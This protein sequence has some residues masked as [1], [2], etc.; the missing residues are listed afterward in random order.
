MSKQLGQPKRDASQRVLD[1]RPK[2]WRIEPR[3]GFY[4][5]IDSTGG[6][7]ARPID[8][9]VAN[10]IVESVNELVLAVNERD[11]LAYEVLAADSLRASLLDAIRLHHNQHTDDLCWQDD[12]A[13]Y[14]AAGLPPRDHR[15]G[16]KTAMRANCDRFIENRCEGGGPW[17]SYAELEAENARLTTELANCKK[18]PYSR[19]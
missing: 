14:A 15:V 19:P 17:R 8:L 3:D 18:P 12:D 2:P 16:D 1:Q 10:E 11:S 7:I 9:A 6:F 5:I 13:L 4:V